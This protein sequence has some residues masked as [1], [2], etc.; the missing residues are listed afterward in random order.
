MHAKT[1]SYIIKAKGTGSMAQLEKHLLT[2]Q[3]ALRT[4]SS[5]T[6]IKIAEKIQSK[7]GVN[8]I[9][10]EGSYKHDQ[11]LTQID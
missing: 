8:N 7:Y 6:K 5:T 3:K 10:W 2:K 11:N 4:K 1:G 9:F